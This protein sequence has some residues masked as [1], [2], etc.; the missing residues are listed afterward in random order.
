M[1]DH[2]I[3]TDCTSE[4]ELPFDGAGGIPKLYI[5]ASDKFD[6]GRCMTGRKVTNPAILDHQITVISESCHYIEDNLY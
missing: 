3:E 2:Q 5:G 6:F 1:D 4:I